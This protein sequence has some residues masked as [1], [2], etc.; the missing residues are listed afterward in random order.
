MNFLFLDCFHFVNQ[1]LSITVKLRE[2]KLFQTSRDVIGRKGFQKFFASSLKALGGA[3]NWG[4]GVL[5][6]SA[7]YWQ[8]LAA[9]WS[10]IMVWRLCVRKMLGSI[11]NPTWGARQ[12]LMTTNTFF[13]IALSQHIGDIFAL[14]FVW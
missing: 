9:W 12:G 5:W 14:D 4:W 10:I 1:K 8:T 2:G 6:G 7:W 11:L 13:S 3:W